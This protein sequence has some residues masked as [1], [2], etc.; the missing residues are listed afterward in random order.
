MLHWT[1]W[2]RGIK[3]LYYCRS[4]SIRRADF[5]GQLAKRENTDAARSPSTDYDECLACQ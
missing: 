1:A 4:K 5:A 2:A 3:S